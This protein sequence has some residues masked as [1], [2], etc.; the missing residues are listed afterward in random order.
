MV[1]E[2]GD[3]FSS[4]QRQI[5]CIARVLLKNPKIVVLDE[6]TSAI[7]NTT[8][9]VIQAMIRQR[10]ATSTVLTIAHRL[11]TIIDADKILVMDNGQIAEM[12]TAEELNK[13]DDG[14]FHCL[15]QRQ[16]DASA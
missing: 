6:A 13:N 12:G 9:E 10:F 3:N 2:G 5:F 11:H 16:T 15:W 1:S 4:G 7:D 14:I 8:D